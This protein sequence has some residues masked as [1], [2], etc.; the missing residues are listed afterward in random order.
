M[1]R[2]PV[3]SRQVGVWFRIWVGGVLVE[4]DEW[5]LVQTWV[6]RANMDWPFYLDQPHQLVIGTICQADRPLHNVYFSHS[7][8]TH[9]SPQKS[10]R[11]VDPQTLVCYHS[12]I[13][14]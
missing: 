8:L 7:V 2:L 1:C 14:L 4:S 10:H 11:K 5:L 13:K 6:G 9:K 12:G 3:H